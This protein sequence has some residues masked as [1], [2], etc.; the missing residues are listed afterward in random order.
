MIEQGTPEWYAVRLGKITGSRI[1]DMMA[2]GKGGA[3]SASR[4]NYAAE[5]VCERMTGMNTPS[6][7][8]SY[9]TDRG[10]E[11]EPFA[12]AAYCER[13][14]VLVEQIGFFD[15]PAIPWFGVSPDGFVDDDGTVEIKCPNAANHI[16][17]IIA[18]KPPSKYLPQMQ[19]G[20]LVTGRKWCDYISFH[21]D[22]PEHLRCIVYRIN[23]DAEYQK[24]VEDAVVAFNAE[25]DAI[26][27]KLE[28]FRQ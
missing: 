25:I 19:A 7:F 3:P 28:A 5:L 13:T 12:R 18:G 11:L 16:A 21:P 26:I 1:S 8:S 27:A 2:Q 4:A 9:D 15:H 22:L 20:L 14:E 10:N 24:T 17:T 6:G 23:A